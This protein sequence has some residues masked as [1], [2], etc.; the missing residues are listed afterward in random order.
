V[1]EAAAVAA[2]SGYTLAFRIGALLAVLGGILVVA[3]MEPVRTAVRPEE[4]ALPAAQPAMAE[5]A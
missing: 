3:L 4:A 5:V 2:T 1:G